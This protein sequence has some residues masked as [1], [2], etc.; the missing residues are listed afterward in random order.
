MSIFTSRDKICSVNITDHKMVS[1]TLAKVVIAW[2]GNPMGNDVAE[3]LTAAL[4]N[5]ASPVEYSFRQL[6]DNSAVGFIRYQPLVQPWDENEVRASFKVMGSHGNIMM[7]TRDRTLWEIKDDGLGNK[8]LARNGT[9]NLAEMLEARVN[10][11]VMSVPRLSRVVMARAV[12]GE[13]ASFVNKFGDMDHG[14]VTHTKPEKCKVVSASTGEHVVVANEHIVSI[15]QVPVTQDHHKA[16]VAAVKGNE[17]GKG[18][19]ESVDY[20]RELYKLW[21]GTGVNDSGATKSYIDDIVHQVNSD[22]PLGGKL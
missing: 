10:K 14:F 1:P 16:V 13:F 11:D 7:D 9:E 12:P 17:S 21:E 22:T 15:V 8:F 6:T 4:D 20:W 19:G 18:D 2:T 5:M 3:V